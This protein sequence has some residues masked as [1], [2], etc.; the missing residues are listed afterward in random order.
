M[1]YWTSIEDEA[2]GSF[3]FDTPRF[4][5][6]DG[7]AQF[8][9]EVVDVSAVLTNARRNQLLK[10][11]LADS[12]SKEAVGFISAKNPSAETVEAK[13]MIEMND[14]LGDDEL[15]GD[16]EFAAAGG[17]TTPGTW[18]IGSGVLTRTASGLNLTATHTWQP[19]AEKLYR[20]SYDLTW[21][22]GSVSVD[23][24][25]T[26][27]TDQSASASVVD[28]VRAADTT[29]LTIVC[30]AT[31][32][33]TID[34]LYVELVDESA[35]TVAGTNT[36]SA[37]ANDDYV[38]TYVDND[39]GAKFEL[40]ELL[41]FTPT[42]GRL[43][44]LTIPVKV[45]TAANFEIEL[46]TVGD[47][48][49][50]SQTVNTD[51]AFQEV[52]FYIIYAAGMYFQFDSMANTEVAYIE[53]DGITMSEVQDLGTDAVIIMN[54]DGDA[55]RWESIESGFDKNDTTYTFDIYAPTVD[56]PTR[57]ETGRE[58]ASDANLID[59]ATSR[60]TIREYPDHH[61]MEDLD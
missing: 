12:A 10:V 16:G 4:A 55:G 35:W 31:F 44:K 2:G 39:T 38:V 29:A 34:N 25:G 19:T 48:E 36:V 43:Y 15:E 47:A 56:Y 11:V 59:R 27:G 60:D 46:F 58:L 33:G 13:D 40:D 28:Y 61:D 30:D 53:N 45:S 42:V 32:A 26:T 6:E 51:D 49:L 54:S 21:S 50:S 5:F 9:N 17:W 23:L 41:G 52:D 7:Y 8:R 18:S 24:G 22:A 20:V 14:L 57:M 37:D 3:G 1:G